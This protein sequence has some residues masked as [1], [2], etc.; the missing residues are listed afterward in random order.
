MLHTD[1]TCGNGAT[2]T[3]AVVVNDGLWKAPYADTPV[4]GVVSV[5]G[6][7]SA[8]NRALVLGALADGPSLLRRPLLA[9]DTRL[10]AAALRRLGT[11][12]DEFEGASGIDWIVTPRML[13]GHTSIDCG[14]AGTVMR[15]VPAV[16]MLAEGPVTFD[17]D[18]RARVRPMHTMIEAIRALGV[19]VDDGGAGTL[20]FT[21]HGSGAVLAS[22]VVIDA[23][24]SSQFVSALLLAAPRFENGC[25]IEHR[26]PAI[27]SMPHLEMTVAMLRERGIEVDV[28]ASDPTN[29]TWT[30]KP[31]PIA[32]LDCTIEPD[33]SNAA[34]FL[35]AAM[36][37][38]G[39]VTVRDWPANTTQ[40]GDR[41][42]ELFNSM[43]GVVSFDA[44][45]LTVRGPEKL[46]GLKAD[47]RDV[48]ELTP[49]IAAVCA[50]AATP[51]H[52]SG[53]AHLRG[54][55]TDRLAALATELRRVGAIAEETDDGLI[56]EPSS[57]LRGATLE[58]YEDHRMAT[59]AAVL[60]L[61]IPDVEVENI[62]T[63]AK[64]LPDFATMWLTLVSGRT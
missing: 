12:I 32:D 1:R 25:T 30:V 50:L 54:H 56:I 42:R 4:R 5:P 46:L 64:T 6:S 27:P 23:S 36:V 34:P 53:I 33:L 26:G 7:K 37:T 44:S 9:R 28:E 3:L 8:T 35:A 11:R 60:G 15:F 29:A 52:L 38:G 10:M 40:A 63:T 16:A 14:L 2:T 61:R 39:Q 49:V 22:H 62:A 47:L 24:A 55:E 31:G 59:A 41:L 57:S 21:V 43:G 48:G 58:T 51:S 20:P 17:G 45:G 18:E 19:R 13:K